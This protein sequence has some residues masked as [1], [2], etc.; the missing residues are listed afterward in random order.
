MTASSPR[1]AP[2]PDLIEESLDE[3]VFLFQRWESELTSLTRNLD[4]IWSWTEDRLQGALDGVRVAGEDIVRMT[5]EG[6]RGEDLPKVTTCAHLLAARSVPAARGL[7]ASAVA[8]ATGPQLS[9]MVRGIELADLDGSF[10]PVTNV[11]ASKGPE[12][13]AALC[14]LKAFRRAKPTRELTEAFESKVPEFQIA[15]LRA[16]ACAPDDTFVRY[17][18]TALSSDNPEVRRTAIEC[19][20]RR[21]MPEAWAAAISLAHAR[22]P[23]ASSLLSLIALLGN[24][25]EHQIVISC[26]REPALQK[27]GLFALGYIGTPEAVEI[28]LAG[29]R[30]AKLARA[31]GEAY[32]AITGADLERD[33]LAAPEPEGES[34]P[35]LDEDDLDANLVPSAE[36]LW[37]LPN[38]DAVR[39]HW[40]NVRQQF[41]PGVRHIRGRPA[42]MQVLYEAIA[43]GPMLRRPG[44]ITEA[45]VRTGGRYDVEPRAFVHVQRRMMNAT[46]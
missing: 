17:I 31:A 27:S 11:L 41:S 4:E 42:S 37:P 5:E 9:A 34:L 22:N 35:P 16:A 24:A 33:H 25:D 23:E 28:C 38:V 21:R 10:A 44:F 13:S 2:L 6:L 32:C 1:L 8:E 39:A 18:A 45:T 12:H 26:L 40:Q 3:S 20:I 15:A 43:S 19:G 14:R 30:D 36:D 29:M 7:L 46:R